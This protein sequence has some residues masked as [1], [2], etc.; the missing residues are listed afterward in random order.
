MAKISELGSI[1]GANTR[2]EDLFVIVNLI[3]GDDGTK[4]ITRR[5][6]VQAIQYEIFDRITITGGQISGVT[7]FDS[8]IRDVVIDD[9]RM[10]DSEITR[11]IFENG[12]LRDSNGLRLDIVDSFLRTSNI[13]DSNGVN[14]II[15]DSELRDSGIFDSTGNNMVITNSEFND[16]TGN[17]VIL[18]NSV[19]DT[20]LFSNG[21][22]EDSTANN[23]TITE[24]TFTDGGIF[25]STANNVTITESTFADGDIFDSNANNIIITNSQFSQGELFDSVANT[26][27]I[28]DST[29]TDGS[30]F[31]STAN[32][33]TITESNIFDSNANNI[34][35]TNSKFEDGTVNTSII[36][37]STFQNGILRDS[38][39]NNLVIENS[40]FNN[41]E[42]TNNIWSESFLYDSVANNVTF[43][44]GALTS[45]TANTLII[46]DSDFS[47]GTGNNNLFTSSTL[48]DSLITN[49]TILTTD[50]RNGTI[51]ESI[52]SN[53]IILDSDA[54]NI[55]VTSSSFANG[56]IDD[57]LMTNVEFVDGELKDFE[58]DLKEVFD[59]NIHE[60][61]WFALKN[62]QTGKTEKF[63]YKQFYDELAKSV[64][65]AL[66]VHVDVSQGRDEWPGSMLQP[67]KSLERAC[68]LAFEKAGGV[69]DR[70][71][72]NNAVHISVGPG[73]YYTKGNLKL[74]DDCSATST[75]G[76]Y[77]T[78]I[79][80]LPGYENNNCWL[81]GSGGYLQGFSY[82]NWKVDNF[83]FPEGG[84]AV[85][86]RPGAK[87]RRSPYLRDSTQLSNF[88][89]ADVEP[90]LNPFNTKGTIAD[91]GRQFIL[92][93]GYT[94]GWNEGDEV[95]F[96]SG[97]IGYISWDDTM[98]ANLPTPIVPGDLVS[99]RKIFVRNLKNNVG[100][101]VGDTVTTESGGI[102][103]VESIGI[104]DFPN[105]AVGRGGGCVL[106]DRRVLDPD[107]LYT[108]VLCFG[109]TP[110]TQNGIGYVARDGA[111]VNGIGSL[112]IFTR[113]AFYALNG[114]QVTLNNSG[115]QFGDISM[116]AKG[117]SRF[118]QPTDTAQE[119]FQNTA[120]S[121]V[122]LEN[123]VA[124][125]DDMVDHLTTPVSDGGL[126]YELYDSVKCE[127][128]SGIILDGV[129]LDIAMDSNY[130]GRLAGITYR[131]PISYTVI[132][133][134]QE[135]T[136]GAIRY[137]QDRIEGLFSQQDV[138]I[139]ERANTSF[140]ETL[141]ILENDE[142]YA[143]PV[144]FADTGV[145]EHR[146]AR[147]LLQ[148]NK[149]LI[150]DVFVDWIDNNE[151]FFAY[152]SIKCRRDTEE[153]I[154][155]AV[156]YDA[157]LD[158]NYNSITAGNA[159]YM[160]TARKVVERQRDETIGA[161]KQLK[162]QTNQ[163]VDSLGYL[164]AERVDSAF[165]DILGILERTGQQFTATFA[166]YDGATGEFV[167]TIENH[168]LTVGTSVLLEQ[169]SFV[170]RCGSDNYIAEISHPRVT[171]PIY[172][173]PIA[174]TSVTQDT[175]TINVGTSSET[176]DH[177]YIRSS[178]NAVQVVPSAITFSDDAGIPVDH[179][180]ARK[181]LQANKS[182]I[183]DH[184]VGWIN[185]NFYVYDDIKC[186]RDTNLYILP[187]I[188][189][190]LALGTNFNSVQAGIAYYTATAN[191]VINEQIDPTVGAWGYVKNQVAA[192]ISTDQAAIYRTDAAADEIID[193]I[194]NG[195][196]NVDTIVWSDPASNLAYFT[197]TDA[198][199]DPAS[200]IS[201]VTVAS[202]GLTTDD[203]V[204]FAPYS[205][206]FTCDVD[207]DATQHSYPRSTD[208]NFNTPMQVT[209]VTQDTFTVNVGTSAPS[210]HTFISAAPNAVIHTS[211]QSQGYHARINL[212][213][214]KTFLQQDV[215]SYLNAN[216]FTFDGD[217]C[218]RDT[219]FILDAVKRDIATG[220]NYHSV[221]TGLAYRSGT[222]GAQVVIT[223]QLNETIGAV[224]YIRDEIAAGLTGAEL[225]RSNAAFNEIT[226]ILAN[227]LGSADPYNFGT[228]SA[229]AATLDA[230]TILQLNRTFMIAE[231]TAY[232]AANYPDLEYDVA[233]C[234]RDTGF[235]IDAASWDIQHGSNVASANNAKFYFEH[236]VATLGADEVIPTADTFEHIAEVAFK[237]VRDQAVIPTAGNAETQDLSQS[238]IGLL[239]ASKVRN[240]INI[241]ATAIKDS[242]AL[243]V[244]EFVEPVVESGYSSAV[245]WINGQ[246]T[247]LQDDVIDEYL[248][249]TFNGLPYNQAK[250]F[251][252]VGYILDA[253]SK[254][255]EY[256]GNASTLEAIQYYFE[257]AYGVSLDDGTGIINQVN[258]LPL[259]QRE[260][261]KLAFQ[262]L[263]D[264]SQQ[265]VRNVV[266]TPQSGNAEAQNT[267]GTA[268]TVA[269]AD[270][271]HDLVETIA[272]TMDQLE[273]PVLPTL[274]SPVADPNQTMAR[275]N[276]QLNK[277]FVQQ[278][279]ISYLDDRYF[280]Y[281]NT[282]CS[283][284]TGTLMDAVKRDV[285]TG[286]NFNSIFNGLAYRAGTVSTDLVIAE[287]LE[288]TIG[289]INYI[290]QNTARKVS[291]ANAKSRVE[292]GFNEIVDIMIYGQP[293][294]DTIVW[295]DG[296][297]SGGHII[298]REQI[299]SNREFLQKE[300]SSF[301]NEKYYTY[302]DK[303]CERDVG[304]I[305][306]AVELDLLLGTNY[307][308]VLAGRAY[309]SP[310]A[311]STITDEQPQ[312]IAAFNNLKTEIAAIVSDGPSLTRVNASIDEINDIIANDTAD[313]LVW[314]DP[315]VD[316]NR[317]YAREQLQ[318]NRDFIIAETIA[319]IDEFLPEYDTV[320]CA[321]DIGNILDAVRRDLILGTD[322]NTITAGDAYLRSSA[323]LS[324][325][326]SQGPYTIAGIEY[327]RDQVK[328]LVS[329][330]DA[331][332]DALFARVI[333]VL[334]GSVTA[335][336]AP[337]YPNHAGSYDTTERSDARTAIQTNR[338]TIVD[339]MQ[340]WI[341]QQYPTHIYDVAKCKRDA[342]Y[343]LDA[344]THD[345]LYGG[346]SASHI[347]ALAYFD[348]TESQLGPDEAI[349]TVSAFGYLKSLI[350]ANIA[351]APEQDRVK[352]LID[353][354]ID[355]INAGSISGMP[356]VVE[357]DLTGLVTTDHDLIVT[358]QTAIANQ[359]PVFIKAN[360]PVY[361][362]AKCE[363]DTGFI[364]D[365][366]SHDVQY[367]G[368]RAT[369]ANAGF[370]FVNGINTL[371]SLQRVSTKAAYLRLA[372][373]MS[374]VV[375]ETLVTVSSG[376]AQVQDTSGLPA[377]AT[378]AT[379]VTELGTIIA[380][381]VAADTP[382]NLPA[383]VEPDVTWVANNYVTSRNTIVGATSSLA[384]ATTLFLNSDYDNETCTR[385]LGYIID[386]VRRDFLTGSTHHTVTAANA[387]L[388]NAGAYVASSQ[389]DRTAQVV[390]Y[391]R[392]L[393]TNL[394]L[395]TSDA[396]IIS[397]FQTVID[398][399]EGTTSTFG[400]STYPTT[401]GSYQ[402]APRIAASIGIQSNIASLQSD[403]SAYIQE[404]YPNVYYDNAK[405]SRDLGHIIDAVRR[406]L[407]LGTNHNS[408]TAANAYLRSTSGYPANGQST[409]TI[410]AVEF[411][412][413]K[414][415][416]LPSVES[417]GEVNGL[418]E[419]VIDVL[420]GSVTTFE[421]SVFPTTEGAS[422]Q[423]TLDREEGSARLQANKLTFA[424]EL[425][426]WIDTQ[427]AGNIAPFTDTFVYDVAKCE[428]D[429]GFIID[430]LTH[431]IKYGGNSSSR[432]SAE[433]Y[434]EGTSILTQQAE[435]SAAFSQLKAIIGGYTTGLDTGIITSVQTLLDIII[436]VL[437][438]GSISGM[439]ALVEI[440][441]TGLDVTEY[442]QITNSQASIITDTV[443]YVN[444]NYPTYDVAD[445]ERD[446]GFILDGLSFDIKYGGNTAS[447]LSAIAYFDAN[448]SQ[449]GD[450]DEVTASIGA[451]TQLKTLV[452]TVIT[453]TIG[454]TAAEVTRA[455]E[456][457]DII[458]DV[459]T[460]GNLDSLEALV[461]VDT[462]GYTLTEYDEIVNNQATVIAD[463]V[464]WA[465][466]N[467][468]NGLGYNAASC[469]R[470]V[471]YLLDC[472]SFDIQHGGNSATIQDA[473]MYF[474]N[475]YT[476]NVLPEYQKRASV[477]AFSHLAEVVR[478]VVNAETV[479]PSTGNPISQ[480]IGT[481]AGGPIA[482]G[483]KDLVNI[484]TN[485]VGESSL[486]NLP[487]EIEPD[488]AA[489]DAEYVSAFNTITEVKP[490]LQSGVITYLSREWN[491]L[492]Y[493]QAKCIR[494]T[495]Y[496]IDA[497]SHDLQYKGTA[498]IWNA[499]QIYFSNAVN[500]L[501]Y[502][503]REPTKK[504]FSHMAEV[505]E[506][507]V[508]LQTVVPSPGNTVA[509]ITTGIG[510]N[511]LT[512]DRAKELGM[513]IANIVE[514]PDGDTVPLR[515]E[516]DYDWVASNY[517]TGV[518][519]IEASADTIVT[520]VIDYI[521][522]NWNGLSYI[523]DSCRRD[524]GFIID[525]VSHDVQ[526]GGNRATRINAQIYFEN[527]IS[528]LP[529]ST[530]RQT[531]DTYEYLG[532]LVRNIIQNN[533]TQ[534]L[535]YTSTA[536]DF[537]QPAATSVDG[538]RAQDLVQIIE[539]VIRQDDI[540]VL[541]SQE[542]PD[543]SWIDSSLV[544]LG[545]TI[546]EST[547]TLADSMIEFIRSEF[548]VLDYNRAKCYRDVQY[549]LD[550]FSWDLNYDSN[551]ASRWNAEFYFW[552]NTLRL[553]EDQRIPT[554]KSYRE[555]GNICAS[556]LQGELTGQVINSGFPSEVEV[557]KV[558]SLANIYYLTLTNNSTKYLPVRQDPSL[559]W[560]NIRYQDAKNTIESLKI[561]LAFDTV[562]FVG[563]TYKF[564]DEYLTRRDAGNLLQSVRN[565]FEFKNTA[566]GVGGSSKATL[567]YTA[568]FFDYKGE[569][570]FPT[571]NPPIQGLRY[572]GSVA[573]IADLPTTGQKPYWSYIVTPTPGDFLTNIWAG[574]VYY[575]DGLSWV[576]AGT[577][578]TDLLDAFV[579]C[580]ER[581][582]TN[583][584]ANYSPD[585]P[586][587]LM[588]EGLIGDCIIGNVLKPS[589]LLFGALVE[590]IAHQF[591]GAS[592]GVNR[593][594]LP[595]NFRNL[596]SAIS[597]LASV[598][599]EDGGRIRWSGSDELNNQYFAR[600]L[601]I[602]G[603]TGRIEGRPFTS[604]VRKLARR[605]SQSRA[606]V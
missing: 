18:T 311:A 398:V 180:N 349:P 363:R 298:A 600:G 361:D 520:G 567:T 544:T 481:S 319:W 116:R 194:N 438:A 56:T 330:P 313:P 77:A 53:N 382:A 173:K 43:Q 603:R 252:D 400:T 504:A 302:D 39:A 391:A 575:W 543:L 443:T 79:E 26:L 551:L 500:T 365:A 524:I 371:P 489:Y 512:G 19:I 71:D 109:F 264:A 409:A 348:G 225:T 185:N 337:S 342:G 446:V 20:S 502:E 283:G 285:L 13:E 456:L 42:G 1:S 428:R 263:A 565:D 394:T 284:D 545:T 140:D 198:T 588:I 34:V 269:T 555:L 498:A 107:S 484:T 482:Q 188:E 127:R 536:Q 325:I 559:D 528:V 2:S 248:I 200:G 377:T 146:Q 138:S 547:T 573:A 118:F 293:A 362:Q 452:G 229:S 121:A 217:K 423:V 554:G 50:F 129:G 96:S 497:I 580:W 475:A 591:N 304:Y 230:R 196:D 521:A 105:P 243:L 190:D 333:D 335:Y 532:L 470:D 518:T 388:R 137:L 384:A 221:Y 289:A 145:D 231:A 576:N 450:A 275:Q 373:V 309:R 447:R 364:I 306:D 72:V 134:Q 251:R 222:L 453:N 305:V 581:I 115:S 86:Y 331:Q 280:T 315:G 418:F 32:N 462:A 122:L 563:A 381:A 68:E 542:E 89:R 186:A 54:N 527:A 468:P 317:R 323:G 241:T 150:A 259:E 215:V 141:N 441:T 218:S 399:L 557:E 226:D 492:G 533:D 199:Y 21:A 286:S 458:I 427:I 4:N 508:E 254:D 189:R 112:S 224:N 370:Y 562:R 83:D 395:V 61:S 267:S 193:I 290:K 212:Q 529:V 509:Q 130:W 30:I 106:V 564:V 282:S 586:H 368:N 449:L 601:R 387:Y 347:A 526:Y 595:L 203:W 460:A 329:T 494:D 420:N 100:F 10:E 416:R 523:E 45:S 392:D 426:A 566:T 262:H 114:G 455:E 277:A 47:D 158:T 493:D 374:Q 341:A 414:I 488:T 483:A 5:E 28:T 473:E 451:Y 238:D 487:A 506:Q 321:R 12:T 353:I 422:Y 91:L 125:I 401:A 98:D 74:P 480:D 572:K 195:L 276:L 3:Q 101:A 599:Y 66:K 412:R 553:P 295:G 354:V 503:Q 300:V 24:S 124:I 22:I 29:F 213:A 355:V 159:Y 152:D 236:A 85:A 171:D 584:I 214:N 296:A 378:E 434:I 46:T 80:A 430:A 593:N 220:S 550:G 351:T 352:T 48:D 36:D 604:S 397:L 287:Q 271:L 589:T 417:I 67:V 95:K 445:C 307:N 472:V 176:S 191:K 253:V 237:I 424:S 540:S 166:T 136:A 602:N 31:D 594:A 233:K 204:I 549:L 413:D 261:T 168:G 245:V 385:D 223:E 169:D 164:G 181:Q 157:Q 439:P 292:Q 99:Q 431:D 235:I 390:A 535:A 393:I 339:D 51:S 244:P 474:K 63:T 250:C 358:N 386:A 552:N 38:D 369:L 102:G 8:L 437:D 514:D 234:E 281:N 117:T 334:N 596:G 151:E 561:D 155:P 389:S 65:Q 219:G 539:S 165:D 411:A 406:D 436:D 464:T 486:A 232:V 582:K 257:G 515:D 207:G 111:G 84:F 55:V 360:Y 93:V 592:A 76:Q 184:L 299:Q 278:E 161:Y 246:R 202:H 338:A 560:V 260:P 270:S 16:G 598:Q 440:D 88:L 23:V 60:E 227:G 403:V 513:Y 568:A 160:A 149:A 256:G 308:S 120:F 174:I 538:A 367:T 478:Q 326:N 37:D 172:N 597:A 297:L 247:R 435:S 477:R 454:A 92:Q 148:D 570:V 605:A 402:T 40:Q 574:T 11:T 359:T 209:A 249:P 322:H 511:P 519:N 7:I 58:M 405:C 301:L 432:L 314:T 491:G 332:I 35:I 153:Y 558:K 97:A 501:P 534:D 357:P 128:D 239:T 310:I 49:S 345:I 499:S 183:Q 94:G 376:N 167:I 69:Y 425:T 6:L 179:R 505:I 205:F 81:I 126:G 175:I 143:N 187:A 590:S 135:E 496:I 346:N 156:K 87:L 162:D 579:G 375:T 510:A 485:V 556:V 14:M 320:K 583:L 15:T 429:T 569:L 372:E 410:A 25:D 82:T 578:N 272:I 490:T 448:V 70:N 461:E 530:R 273:N 123:E 517:T 546:D 268:V 444:T 142:S 327:A 240:L 522:K 108:Y 433:A 585:S 73:T 59:P 265:V 133:D 476:T 396:S 104:D 344:V 242:R 541:A 228:N 459:L 103:I 44:N 291:G 182:Y 380:N 57:T 471:G 113:C 197:P 442:S 177:I 537:S 170:F 163:L 465:N 531:A 9:S 75:S 210:I 421:P 303:T 516:P 316:T 139:N 507:V 548:D 258:I 356:A 27:T 328:A 606:I 587:D 495:G 33:L 525:A 132:G 154:L 383:R 407:V 343:I 274:V 147:E 119:M 408:V 64:T 131:S 404:T 577:N 78:V 324:Y 201:V 366:I 469:E 479:T 571:F 90:P 208:G 255:I 415:T 318:L 467:V 379:T 288:E 216:Y 110:R 279:V 336:I 457:I 41:G 312:T 211:Q 52:L 178:A 463:S 206:T 419:R 144:T 17:N 62:F 192:A 266:V 350:N 294:A 466:E 340:D